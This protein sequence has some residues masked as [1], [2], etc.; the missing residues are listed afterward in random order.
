MTEKPRPQLTG[1]VLDAPD[2]RGLAAFYRE[3]LDWKVDMDEPTWVKLSPPGGGYGLAFQ[4]EPNYARPTWP[5][6]VGRPGMMAH[7]DIEV[8]DL[9]TAGARAVA[10]GAELAG[11]QP[12]QDVRVYLDPVGHPFCLWVRTGPATS[13]G[14]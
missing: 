2:P 4:L 1:I 6:E 14:P 7:L 13:P 12:Q 5:T 3:L 11:F 10:L 9:E 8:D